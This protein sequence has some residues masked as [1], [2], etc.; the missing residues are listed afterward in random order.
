M[1]LEDHVG[2]ILRKGRLH[3]EV[4]A[5]KAASMAKITT[6][7]LALL[8]ETGSMPSHADWQALCAMVGLNPAKLGT[9]LQGWAPRTPDLGIWRELRPISTVSNG[10]S[11]NCYLIWDEV[12][13]EA[14][15]FDTGFEAN[16]VIDLVR[17]YQLQ[18]KHLFI[19]HSHSDHV[20]ALP[21]LRQAFPKIRIHTG[22]KAA[23]PEHRN[24]THDFVHLGNLRISNRETPGHAEDGTTYVVGNWPEDAPH[25]AIVGDA[26]FAGSMGGAAGSYALAAQRIREQLLSLPGDTLLCPGHGPL[27]TVAEEREHNPFF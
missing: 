25:V 9:I 20:A 16:P 11:V 22:D 18:L 24:R 12:T 1:T 21:H 4:A 15:L 6:A 8:E 10:M 3:L 19:T 17:E 27:T 5:E 13:L 7:D 26:L 14:A 2:D 23:S